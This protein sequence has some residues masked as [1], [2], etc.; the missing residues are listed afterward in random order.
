[1]SLNFCW[2]EITILFLKSFIPIFHEHVTLASLRVPG[3]TELND[4]RS[5]RITADDLSIENS[6]HIFNDFVVGAPLNLSHPSMDIVWDLY[7]KVAMWGVQC[8]S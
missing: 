4:L 5:N 2:D 8:F 3:H 7:Y 6:A 1:M